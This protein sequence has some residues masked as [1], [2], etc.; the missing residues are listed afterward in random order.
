LDVLKRNVSNV[1]GVDIRMIF[2]YL[3]EELGVSF[4]KSLEKKDVHIVLGMEKQSWFIF[5]A[6][7]VEE[8]E[9]LD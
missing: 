9:R 1:V 3:A 2:V 8:V 5:H 6:P 7:N 4:V